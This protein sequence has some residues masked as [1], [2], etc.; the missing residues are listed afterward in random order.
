MRGWQEISHR[1]YYKS[2]C[3][4]RL[5]WS[6]ILTA[7]SP[8]STGTRRVRLDPGCLN[9]KK[10]F[11]VAWCTSFETGHLPPNSPVFM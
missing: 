1:A 3:E 10:T 5:W 4:G 7:F 11:Q 9:E 2:Q 8:N 6:Q